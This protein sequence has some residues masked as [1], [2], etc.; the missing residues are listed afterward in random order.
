MSKVSFHSVFNYEI[1]SSEEH[2]IDPGWPSQDT[3]DGATQD[4]EVAFSENS[5]A[6]RLLDDGQSTIGRVVSSRN[7]RGYLSFYQIGRGSEPCEVDHRAGCTVQGFVGLGRGA[8]H[9]T[10]QDWLQHIGGELVNDL[11]E[12]APGQDAENR[13]VNE[14]TESDDRAGDRDFCLC[15]AFDPQ[16]DLV[17]YEYDYTLYL[18]EWEGRLLSVLLND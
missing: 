6:P 10:G 2:A 3:D 15:A 11:S 17:S 14:V 16:V 8:G 4:G 18:D 12:C 9:S 1:C 5:R 13:E 7:G